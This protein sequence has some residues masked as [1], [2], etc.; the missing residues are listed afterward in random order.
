MLHGE[1]HNR[2]PDA[3][4]IAG[5]GVDFKPAVARGGKRHAASEE[6]PAFV[7]RKRT[8]DGGRLIGAIVDLHLL[9]GGI[10]LNV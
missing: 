5:R 9:C 7:L 10:G 3:E 6:M 8:E 2:R 4:G 1:A